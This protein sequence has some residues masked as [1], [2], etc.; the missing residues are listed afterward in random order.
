MHK[1]EVEEL[2]QEFDAARKNLRITFTREDTDHVNGL[3]VYVVRTYT[4]S[5]PVALVERS[6]GWCLFCLPGKTT[7]KTGGI[8]KTDTIE[9]NTHTIWRF[10]E[11]PRRGIEEALPAAPVSSSPLYTPERRAG[12]NRRVRRGS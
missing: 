3:P 7:D 5:G 8:V 10:L 1:Q 2:L 6:P 9:L 11:E 12:K 4:L